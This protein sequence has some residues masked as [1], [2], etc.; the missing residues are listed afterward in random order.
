MCCGKTNGSMEQLAS[1]LGNIQLLTSLAKNVNQ[2]DVPTTLQNQ[3]HAQSEEKET[4]LSTIRLPSALYSSPSDRNKPLIEE[5]DQQVRNSDSNDD[6]SSELE[7]SSPSSEEDN[8]S[9]DSSETKQ[10]S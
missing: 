3:S 6:S 10:N 1:D 4:G 7:S 5:L 2:D 9:T 8:A